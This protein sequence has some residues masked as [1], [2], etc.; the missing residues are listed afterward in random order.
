MPQFHRPLLKRVGVALVAI[1]FASPLGIH[2][3]R[4]W[5]DRWLSGGGVGSDWDGR[6]WL[7][8]AEGLGILG[9]MLLI[10]VGGVLYSRGWRAG[11]GG[12]GFELG[13]RGVGSGAG[14]ALDGLTGESGRRMA[15][16]QSPTPVIKVDQLRA[17]VRDARLGVGRVDAAGRHFAAIYGLRRE[18]CDDILAFLT[19]EGIGGPDMPGLAGGWKTDFSIE[20]HLTDGTP[21]A[22]QLDSEA[23]H[24]RCYGYTH[25]DQCVRPGLVEHLRPFTHPGA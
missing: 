21:F 7:L 19:D 22:I 23:T 11:R 17:R 3:G 5:I 1:G 14:D 10:V 13:A 8:V 16:M 25:G 6:G 24:W 15:A 4:E 20:G 12:R 9:G 2:L 18:E